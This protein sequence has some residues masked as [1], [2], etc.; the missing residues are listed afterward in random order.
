M[1]NDSSYF[2]EGYQITDDVL[3]KET[4]LNAR[5]VLDRF[6]MLRRIKFDVEKTL[7][8]KRHY[9]LTVPLTRLQ[10]RW[11]KALLYGKNNNTLNS[12]YLSMLSS[13][14]L[15]SILFQ[16]RKVVN[17]PKQILLKREE[18]RAREAKRIDHALHAGS[19]FISRENSKLLPPKVNSPEWRSEQELRDLV[20]ERLVL[21]CGKLMMLD[22]LLLKLKQQ[23]SRCLIFSQFTETLDILEEYVQYRFGPVSQGK[24]REEGRREAGCC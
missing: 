19:E 5:R 17:H 18:E 6:M 14:Q 9:K 22:R 2:D 3:N 12:S 20:G 1:F 21:S 7:L 15:M 8:K 11:Y 4:C 24:R 23:Q 13:T 16:L 10:K